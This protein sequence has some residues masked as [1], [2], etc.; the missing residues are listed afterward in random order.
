MS[1]R[2]RKRNGWLCDGDLLEL[3]AFRTLILG[4][5]FNYQVLPL[6]GPDLE[7]MVEHAAQRALMR[8]G[9]RDAIS[10]ADSLGMVGHAGALV[11]HADGRIE[12]AADP[13]SDG[14]AAG[15]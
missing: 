13:R 12:G 3:P 5:F 14:A 4:C 2:R 8:Q 15:W 10:D 6:E 1:T 11:R 9:I 7:R